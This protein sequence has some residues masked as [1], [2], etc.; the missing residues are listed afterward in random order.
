MSHPAPPLSNSTH[1]PVL[2]T[3]RRFLA[4]CLVALGAGWLGTWLQSRLFPAASSNQATVPV[5]F[6]L[7]DLPVGSSKTV[8]Y[9]GAQ[10]IVLRTPEAV[11]ALSLTCTHLG[12]R[13]QWQSAKSEFYCPCHE[14]RFDRFGEVLS[15]PPQ[16]PL[17]EFTV[18]V[19]GDQ[20]TVGEAA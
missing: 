16:L 17:D 15:G 7:A 1:S 11:R 12:C 19:T 4:W 14:G 9:A 18:K 10:V 6:P 13:L 20:V 2:V 3:R 5:I 8:T